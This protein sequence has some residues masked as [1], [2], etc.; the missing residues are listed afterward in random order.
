MKFVFG[1]I[2][3]VLTRVAE[4][5]DYALA[6]HMALSS[7]TAT[8]P[9]L[10]FVASLAGVLGTGQLQGEVV[11]LLFETWPH[12]VSEPIAE[13]VTNVL[14]NSRPG[15]VTIS[16]IVA[17]TLASNG[18]EAI[19]VGVNRAYGL[20]E[21]RS[22]WLCRLESLLFVFVASL[23][24]VTLALLVVL[25]PVMW[26]AAIS[27]APFL[28]PLGPTIQLARYGITLLILGSAIMLV[29]IFLVASSP[30]LRRI[31]PGALLT[32]GL[33]LVGG[34]VFSIYITD[35]NTYSRLYAGLGGVFA[36]L[37]FLWLV[38][39]AFLLGAEFNAALAEARHPAKS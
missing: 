29:H 14:G 22:F 31:W 38:A 13:E 8:F 5:D 28:E 2:W 11:R 34:W 4:H 10:I 15:L 18:V 21:T 25:W 33:W 20:V 7:L 12:A 19:R 26:Q 24:L 30:P 3:R 17:L 23:A 6:S 16:A 35:F 36:A 9:F 27:F 39:L 32:L 1:L 37:F